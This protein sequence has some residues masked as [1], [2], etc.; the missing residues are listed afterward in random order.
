MSHYQ[1]YGFGYKKK[2]E[3]RHKKV[4]ILFN[5]DL[6]FPSDCNRAAVLCFFVEPACS[7]QHSCYNFTSMYVRFGHMCCVCVHLS[8]LVR[9]ITCTFMH[10]FQNNLAHVFFFEE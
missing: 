3:S 4:S 1:S 5:M 9:A 7:E 2:I 8:R 6:S 10:G